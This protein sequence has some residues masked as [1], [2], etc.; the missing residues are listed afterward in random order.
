M[1]SQP[2]NILAPTVASASGAVMTAVGSVGAN[3]RRAAVMA[4]GN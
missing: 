1:A 4:T 2:K 3:A